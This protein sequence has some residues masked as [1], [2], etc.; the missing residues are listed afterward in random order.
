MSL[1]SIIHMNVGFLGLQYSF[2]LQQSSM[3]PLYRYLGADESSLPLLWLAGPMTG[4]LVQPLIGAISDRTV[5]R[6]GRRRPYFL[7][8]AILCSLALLAMPFSPTLWIAASLLWILDAANNVTMEPYRAWISDQLEGPQRNTGYLI[9]SAMTGL[10]Q[11]L[12]YLTP[13][14]IVLLGVDRDAVNSHQIPWATI[15]A[16][17]IGAGVSIASMSWTLFST[18]KIVQPEPPV[19]SGG[20]MSV[21]QTWCDIVGAIRAM[22]RPMRQLAPVMLC[23]W[24]AFFCY[25]QYVTLSLART[26]FHTSD[27]AS[28]GFREAVLLNGQCGAFYNFVAFIAA[29][30]MV[31]LAS[32]MGAGRV[33]ALA[34][35]AAGVGML[36][37]PDI[38]QPMWLALPML[39]IGM[40]WASLMGNPYIMLANSIPPARAGIY[41]GIF[42]LFIVIP[43]LIQVVTMPLIYPL[44]SS[45][46]DYVLILAGG[47]L[48]LGAGLTARLQDA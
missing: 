47:L 23:Q 4:L 26:V 32:R 31:P 25:W 19:A 16:F 34:L 38:D 11:T 43:M 36:A 7:I 48:L 21:R 44:L 29:L 27:P 13:T 20:T 42:N 30:G 1:A 9:Q 33:H 10:G 22:P 8:G 2:G 5:S 6:W 15:A 37:L 18:R 46:P 39:G 41:M 3:S 28:S 35:L 17:L 45:R 14:L 40:A 12:S 24:Y